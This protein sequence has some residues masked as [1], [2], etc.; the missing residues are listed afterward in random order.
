M[1]PGP[2]HRIQTRERFVTYR[3]SAAAAAALGLTMIAMPAKAA[4]I[5]TFEGNDCAGVFGAN[6][7][8]CTYDGSPII[9][10]LDAD[11][12]V[13]VNSSLFPTVTGREFSFLELASGTG[14]WTYTP[15]AGDPLITAYVAKGGPGFNLFSNDGDPNTG[16]WSTP[17]NGANGR[18][19]GLSHLSFY[20]TGTVTVPEPASLALFG[21]GLAGLGLARRRRG[22]AA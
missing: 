4:L 16:I 7:A 6:F 17:T 15:G 1:L 19:Y 2:S 21:V 10:K 20:D 11:G 3:F 8:S 12:S 14:T 13:Q 22:A 18:P 9:A 5:G